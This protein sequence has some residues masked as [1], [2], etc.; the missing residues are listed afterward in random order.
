[1]Y[2]LTQDPQIVIRLSDAAYIPSDAE[3]SDRQQ[4]QEWLSFGNTPRPAL[5][6]PEVFTSL[7]PWQ[8]RQALNLSG[9]RAAVEGMIAASPIE[10]NDAWKFASEFQ[11]N[12][13]MLVQ[14]T[15]ALGMTSAEVDDLF[16]LGSTLQPQ[17]V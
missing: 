2:Q 3:N 13:D 4:Y 5:V 11:R 10:I 14:M 17:I 12:N 16:R 6:A 15:A 9:H 1:M 7:S 8:V